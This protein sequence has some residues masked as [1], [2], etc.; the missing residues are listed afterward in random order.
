MLRAALIVLMLTAAP[1]DNAYA[2]NVPLVIQ[3]VAVVDVIAGRVQ[4]DMTVEIRGRT[5]SAM[6]A[7]RTVRIPRRATVIDGRG[8]YLIPGLWDM[9]V[10]LSFPPGVEQ[11]FP[12]LM[13][14]NGVL[15]ARDMHS[16]LAPIISLK[17][18]VASGTQIGPR[19]FVAGTAVDGPNSYLPGARVVHTPDEAAAAVRELKAAGVDFIKVYSS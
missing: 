7:D 6:S 9:H 13:V 19:L 3:H 8:K 4:P 14:A 17:R 16:F 10:H 1:R 12:P 2:Q 5:I 15:G 11:I 18:A